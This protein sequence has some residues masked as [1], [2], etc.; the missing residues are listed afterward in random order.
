VHLLDV[1]IELATVAEVLTSTFGRAGKFPS[2]SHYIIEF[3]IGV[4]F[5]ACVTHS[6]I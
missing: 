6:V 1:V 5:V 4:D 3:S 2:R